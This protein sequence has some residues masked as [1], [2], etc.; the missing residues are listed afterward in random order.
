METGYLKDK[1]LDRLYNDVFPTCIE[2]C[3]QEDLIGDEDCYSV[4]FWPES[5]KFLQYVD[6]YNVMLNETS[7]NPS[8]FVLDSLYDKIMKQQKGN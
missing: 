6:G 2:D 1:T 4:I 5:E 3:T 7:L 8:V